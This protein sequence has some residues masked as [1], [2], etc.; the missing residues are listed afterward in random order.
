MSESGG[1]PAAPTPYV[2]DLRG[3][4]LPV[5]VQVRRWTTQTLGTLADAHLADVLLVATELVTNA[6]DHGH[7]PREL[8]MSHAP[9]PCRVRIEIDDANPRHPT[10]IP[11]NTRALGGRGMLLVEQ[12]TERWGVHDDPRTGGKTVWAEVSCA[13]PDQQPCRPRHDDRNATTGTSTL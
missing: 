11:P 5:L 13:G 4:E 6:Y 7:G 10:V 3:T 12:L 2:L 1:E 8:R 9:T